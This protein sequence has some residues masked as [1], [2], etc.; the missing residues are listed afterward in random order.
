MQRGSDIGH[1]AIKGRGNLLAIYNENN[2]FKY[3]MKTV[4]YVG[5]R[6]TVA[7]SSGRVE[8]NYRQDTVKRES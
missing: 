1:Y 8:S 7:G 6:R 3:I 5:G 2:V 4:L